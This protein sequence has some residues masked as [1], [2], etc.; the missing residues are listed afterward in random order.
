MTTPIYIF[1]FLLFLVNVGC[2][3]NNNAISSQWA[4]SEPISD[5]E[6][7]AKQG[8][9]FT[10]KDSAGNYFIGMI[11]AFHKSEGGI[12]YAMSFT[13]YYDTILPDEKAIDTLKL[14]ARRVGYYNPEDYIIG[15]DV[16]WARD[17]L[18]DNHKTAQPGNA[19][20]RLDGM[21]ITA[22]G[23]V[24]QYSAFLSSYDFAKK[25]RMFPDKYAQDMSDTAFHP[26]FYLPV[27]DIN[28]AVLR[29]EK[30]KKKRNP[31][32]SP[33]AL[34]SPATLLFVSYSRS[35]NPSPGRTAAWYCS[36]V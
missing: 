16:T 36:A 2:N 32:L 3:S 30:L 9:C 35:N 21:E 29:N 12:W 19:N 8:D 28:D 17:T 10:F 15:I 27:K 14:N 4:E 25:Q 7:H 24:S 31:E 20:V 26:G 6:L 13:N 33:R 5:T 22:E 11:S 23:S 1:V 18:I 34:F